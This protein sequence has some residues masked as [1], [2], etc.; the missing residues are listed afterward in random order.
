MRLGIDLDGVVADFNAGWMQLHAEEFGSELHPNMVDSWNCLHRLGGFVDMRAF[1]S[2]AGPNDHRRSIFRHLTPYPTAVESLRTLA[3]SGHR[4]VIVTTKP[5]W[6]RSD[7]F[8]WLADADLPTT[9]VHVIDHKY[10]VACDVYLDDAPHVL[11][12]L[13]EHRPGATI[14]RFV[15]PW[16]EPVAG[17]LDVADWGRFIEI[18]TERSPE[19]TDPSTGQQEGSH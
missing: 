13:V 19:R 8:S 3:K 2:W 18:V 10:E 11:E 16:N 12:E 15:R 1:W 9:E 7:T 6:A 5:H 14:C 17:T 4:I